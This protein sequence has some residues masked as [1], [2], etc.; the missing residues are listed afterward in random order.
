MGKMKL[1][2]IKRRRKG[3]PEVPYETPVWLGNL[4]NGEFYRPQTPKERK[5]RELILQRCDENARR[6]GID[7]REFIASSMGM[8]TT[9]SV[10]NL[11]A[12]CGNKDGMMTP[13]V[14]DRMMSG[15]GGTPY[16][17]GVAGLS[18]AGGG[19][20][21]PGLTGAAAGSGAG[22]AGSGSGSAGSGI[23]GS[24][25]MPQMPQSMSGGSDGG[26]V[27]T[28]ELCMDPAMAD[29]LFK[30]EYFILDFQT[31]HTRS[32][33]SGPVLDDCADGAECTSPD[34]YVRKIF[35]QSETT[36]A[37]LSGLPASI[38]EATN[39]LSAF[40]FTNE[41]MRTSR[42]RVNKASK[43]TPTAG[44][45]MIA[46]C[47]IS[48]KNNPDANAKMMAENKRMYDT[49]GW[50]CYPPTEGGWFLHENDAFIKTAIELGEPLV[51]AHKGF[52]FQGWSRTHADPMPDVGVVALRYP[53]VNFVI[54]HSAYD[55]GHTEGPFE[56]NPSPMDGGT[57]RL[58]KVVTDN[59][60]KNKNVYA[61]MGSAWCISMRD[62]MVA[63]HYLGKA[64]KYM[65]EDRVVWGSECV[66]FGSPQNQIEAMKA[67]RISQEFQDMY[68]YPEFTDVM[69]RKVF[70][71]TGAKLYRVDP[72]ACRYKVSLSQLAWR[73]QMLD[74]VW[75]PRRH[76]LNNKP[77]IH[78]RRQYI[79]LWRDRIAKGE[80][81]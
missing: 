63:Q 36:V 42:D 48:P 32:G 47:Q 30:T 45:R 26:F 51:C 76:A 67:F 58:W 3:D 40:S 39:D 15:A 6:H 43:L 53:D 69:K 12:G 27:V 77:A 25:S 44:E 4:S 41:D 10:L 11:A 7:R 23:A 54:Y 46:H 21:T 2:W 14:L 70:G 50:K 62:P 68:G 49:R 1:R 72:N 9:L 66:W 80:I 37:V 31:H 16:D 75:G 8:A 20:G 61:E 81:A 71:L 59:N 74:D 55:S 65:G 57:D 38:D 19:A 17:G 79:E 28:P 24:G 5:I 78:T 56:P 73:K 22:G 34:T 33:M 18:A 64:L 35:E 29:K 13:G 60:L 52:P